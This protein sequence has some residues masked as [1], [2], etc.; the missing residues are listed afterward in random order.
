MHHIS[1][2]MPHIKNIVLDDWQYVSAFEYFARSKEKGYDKFTDI[3]TNIANVAK[4]PKDLR[5]DLH[6]YFLTHAEE[7]DING[8]K[9]LKAKTLGKMIDNSLT[10]EGLFTIVLFSKIVVDED[11]NLNYVFQTK[12]SG[13]DTCK[14]P[15][16]MFEELYIPNDLQKVRES[17]IAY[18]ND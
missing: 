5:E 17:I 3:A 8:V 4:C 9:K 7:V 13:N 2:N 6:V 15:M 12:N 18:E 16:G 10:L 11:D 14:T 1:D